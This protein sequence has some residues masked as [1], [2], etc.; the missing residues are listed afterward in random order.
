MIHKITKIVLF[1]FLIL[2]FATESKATHMVGG[3]FSYRCLGDGYFE[4]T[5]TLRRDCEFGAADAFFDNKAHIAVFNQYGQIMKKIG[6]RGGFSLPYVGNDTLNESLIPDCGITG[7]PVCVHEAIYRDTIFLPQPEYKQ[8]YVLVYQRCCRNQTLLN[9]NSPLETGGSYMIEIDKTVWDECNASPAFKSWPDIYICANQPLVFDHSATEPDGDSLVYELYTPYSGATIN[10]PMPTVADPGKY[11][12]YYKPV[13]WADNYSVDNIL[14]GDNPLK[15]DPVTGI[16]TGTPEKEGQ[17][18]V[19]VLVKEYR[20]GYLMSTIRR[21][22][23]YNVRNC[24]DPPIADFESVEAICGSGVH[25]TLVLTNTSQNADTYHWYIYQSSTGKTDTFNTV[26]VD[27]IYDLPSW[28]K[29][30]FIVTIDAY[31]EIANCSDVYTKQIIAVKDELIADFD[32][33]IND[34]YND[35]LDITLNLQDKFEEL[36]PLYTW[37]ESKWVLTFS[38]DTLYAE[39]RRVSIIV[40]KEKK[41]LITLYIDTEEKCKASVEK[42]VSLD[43]AD[44]EFIANPM[45]V[46]KGDPTKFVANP[47]SEWTYTWDSE[48]GLLFDGTDKSDPTFI[49]EHDTKYYVTVTDGICTAYDSIQIYVKDYFDVSISCPDTVCTNSV[50]LVALGGDPNDTIVVYQWSDSNDF[51]NII[52]EGDTVTVDL[53]SDETTFYLRV[54]EG[55]GC[56]NN[57]D[58]TTI[59]MGAI[60]LEYPDTVYYCTNNNSRIIIKNLDSTSNINI[61]WE[62]SPLIVRGQDSLVL[63]I[64]SSVVG[65]YDLVFTAT[66]DYGCELTDTI[67][68]IANEGTKLEL[69]NSIVCGTYTMCFSV[70][71]GRM[72]TYTWD[73][74]DPDADDDVSLMDTPCYMYPKPGVY[75]VSVEVTLMDCDGRAYLEKDVIVPEIL[76]ISLDV[77]SLIY[78]KGEQIQLVASKNAESTIEWFSDSGSIGVGDTLVYSPEGDENIYVVGTDLYDCQD[79][80]YI[81]LEEYKYDITYI[82]PGVRCKGDTV[83]LEIRIN[84][85]ANLKF[86]WLGDNIISGANTNTPKVIVYESTDFEVKITDMDYGCDSTFLVSVIVSD[87]DVYVDADTTELVITNSTNITV[88]DVPANS[89][90]NWSTGETN[91]ETITITPTAAET[92]TQTYCVTV[93]DEYGCTDVDCIDITVIDPACNETDIFIPNAFSPN[94]DGT[95]DVFMVRGRYLRSIDM[96]I[97]DRWGELLFKDSGGEL[98]NWD[99]TFRGKDLPNDA[100]SFRIHVQ[101]EDTDNYEKIGN[102][103]IIK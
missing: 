54:K 25:D 59:Y 17:F 29:D 96:E 45:V 81:F 100:Y 19:G 46:C 12:P 89:T 92:G 61:E 98:I 66:N 35:S 22:F 51:S 69:N 87:I 26:D 53:N 9:I 64:Y 5:L 90:I 44:I 80:A 43:F 55:T 31:S 94:G 78:C 71:G 49:G 14:G 62:D 42:W 18:L 99:G 7:D 33:V 13:T 41:T 32:V 21:D 67:H 83:D 20:D 65:E 63:I 93:T 2:L 95:N 73:F 3:D 79:T 58:S 4:I 24:L 82:D 39:G 103:S 40:P 85:D 60:N 27:Y 84:N 76:D 34:C 10:Y 28:G 56:S 23:E 16:I 77:D 72:G 52:A 36:N 86:E 48:E 91:V 11:T 6:L 38:N 88:Y 75:H 1:S 70:T 50:Q 68:V 37:K 97:Y 8:K 47:H 15:I 30:T 57:V 74:G 102:V 101:C